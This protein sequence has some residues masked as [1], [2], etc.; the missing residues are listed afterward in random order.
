MEDLKQPELQEED[1]GVINAEVESEKP[2]F[3]EK[4]NAKIEEIAKTREQR[5]YEKA[6]K[7]F[8]QRLKDEKLQAEKE[9][10]KAKMSEQERFEAERKEFKLKEAQFNALQKLSDE[11]LGREF[12]ELVADIDAD[13]MLEKVA[14]LKNLIAKQV[15]AGVQ[16][17]LA[18]TTKSA[19]TQTANKPKDPMAWGSTKN[20]S[21][22]WRK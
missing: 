18:G 15:E 4:Q 7:E 3:D 12:V 9:A 14:N 13:K 22:P 17:K 5:A 8:E 11:G 20:T 6:K 1:K 16:S 19:L 21:E 2:V 10:Q